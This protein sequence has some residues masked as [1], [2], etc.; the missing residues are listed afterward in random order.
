MVEAAVS[1]DAKCVFDYNI[2]CLLSCQTMESLFRV[3]ETGKP[4][5]WA[6]PWLLTV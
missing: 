3:S 6:C 5:K 1:V 2:Y 4:V